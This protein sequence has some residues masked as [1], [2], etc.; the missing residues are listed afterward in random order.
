MKDDHIFD[1]WKRFHSKFAGS[2]VVESL[3]GLVIFEDGVSA[4]QRDQ[5]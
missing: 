4:L 2:A 1:L 3:A 5:A